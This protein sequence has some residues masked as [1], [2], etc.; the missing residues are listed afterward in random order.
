MAT[1]SSILADITTLSSTD[2]DILKEYLISLFKSTTGSLE[3]FVTNER[4]SGGLVCPICGCLHIVR[5]GHRKDGTQRYICKDCDKSFVAASNSIVSSTKKD[6][7]VWEKYVNC[8]MHGFSLR[9]TASICGI[10][11]NT[12]FIWRHKVLGA[13][14]N[15]ADSVVLSGIVE[16]DETFFSDS[17]KGNHKRGTFIMPRKARKRG[18]S[19]HKRGLSHEK[20]CVPCAVNRKGLSIAKATNLGRVATKDLHFVYDDRIAP[21]S[22]IVTDLMNSYRRFA[23]KNN[24]ELI[25]LK[26]GK[27]KKGIYNIQHINSY[28]SGLK[29]FMM[30]FKGVSTKHLNNYLIWH[31]FVNYAP[32]SEVDKRNILLKFVMS[33]AMIIHVTDISKKPA[34][35]FTA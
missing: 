6:F 14:Q 28:H 31:N 10:H 25:Q 3:S 11:R 16:A 15:M 8:M 27:S 7:S 4:F 2:K 34:M 9:K 13:L 17:Y 32:E 19:I 12:A 35:P 29:R 5:N 30:K 23:T 1:V 24:L 22:V 33:Q 18:K 26:G 20:V 21:D